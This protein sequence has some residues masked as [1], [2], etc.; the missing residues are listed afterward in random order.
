[1]TKDEIQ[2]FNFEE[3]QRMKRLVAA[4]DQHGSALRGAL[5]EIRTV[6]AARAS[7]GL[8]L[9]GYTPEH[10]AGSI[11]W[12]LRNFVPELEAPGDFWEKNAVDIAEEL[13]LRRLEV[14]RAA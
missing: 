11:R 14:T 9:D 12:Y 8:P 6:A 5:E 10:A 2:R 13:R 7:R 3:D 4:V 1:M